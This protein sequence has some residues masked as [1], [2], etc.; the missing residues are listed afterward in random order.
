MADPTGRWIAARQ[1]KCP[2][3]GTVNPEDRERCGNCGKSLRPSFDEPV[4]P[5]DALDVVGP[6]KGQDDK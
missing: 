6:R 1:W 3:C 4:R 2:A 5:L